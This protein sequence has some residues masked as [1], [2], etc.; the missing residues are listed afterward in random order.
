[1][2]ILKVPVSC[3]E[4]V[5]VGEQCRQENRVIRFIAQ[6]ETLL[7]EIDGRRVARIFIAFLYANKRTAQALQNSEPPLRRLAV[8][9]SVLC[10]TSFFD[11]FQQ[12]STRRLAFRQ[13]LLYHIFYAVGG[14]RGNQIMIIL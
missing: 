9:S 13:I 1:M 2:D 12:T 14:F 7:I 8:F 11:F 5:H 4:N 6:L 10:V 3:Q